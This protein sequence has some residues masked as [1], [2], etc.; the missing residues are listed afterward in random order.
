MVLATL[1]L[2]FG[3]NAA[4]PSDA[5]S[6][7]KPLWTTAASRGTSSPQ[8]QLNS[9][10]L[11]ELLAAGRA[12]PL[13]LPDGS[14]ATFTP[15]ESTIFEAGFEIDFPAYKSYRLISAENTPLRGRLVTL[16]Q[17]IHALI[18]TDTQ[19]FLIDPISSTSRTAMH[20]SSVY[21]GEGADRLNESIAEQIEVVEAE[22]N[23]AE[24]RNTPTPSSVLTDGEL[25]S[26]RLAIATDG[27]YAQENGG[28]L[29]S[30]LDA[31]V[32]RV[33]DL[34]HI[35]QTQ[36]GIAFHLI[37]NNDRIVFLD[38]ASDPYTNFTDVYQL[39][40]QNIAATT[41]LIGKTN[42]DIGHLFSA[43]YFGGFAFTGGVCSDFKAGAVTQ[44][45]TLWIAAHEI[46]H[47]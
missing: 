40:S 24:T 41:S 36:V 37:A 42:Y 46:G 14:F 28:T 11:N 4:H 10:S 7:E 47:S 5:Q 20:S 29:T 38:P 2:L 27:E 44:D 32:S 26:Y 45:G 21:D 16:H 18:E 31:V 6:A 15:T 17:G 9:D 33:S 8:H 30:T 43:G 1:L 19:V 3:L 34:N 23:S 39:L 12:I 13:P 35:Y 25:R 22:H